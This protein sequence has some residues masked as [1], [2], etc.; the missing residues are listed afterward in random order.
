MDDSREIKP[1][2]EMSNK[3]L[4]CVLTGDRGIM[5]Q[6]TLQKLA[7]AYMEKY[8]TKE[9]VELHAMVETMLAEEE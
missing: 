2:I 1:F 5:A 3:E 9:D 7:R 4:F 8:P 6:M